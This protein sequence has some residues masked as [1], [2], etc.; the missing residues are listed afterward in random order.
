METHPYSVSDYWDGPMDIDR[1][2]AWCERLRERLTADEVSFGMVFL[3]P[4]YGK[5]QEEIL[6]VI[7]IHCRVP[8]LLG[9][10]GNSLVS[11]PFEYEGD[12]GISVVLYYLPGA[13]LKPFY[14]DPGQLDAADIEENPGFVPQMETSLNGWLVF[15][16]PFSINSEKLL[17]LINHQYPGTAVHGG[18][19]SGYAETLKT[20]IFLDGETYSSGLVGLAVGGDVTFASL[21][22]QG[23]QPIGQSFTVT[24]ANNNILDGIANRQA[25]EVLNEVFSGLSDDQKMK[26]R[27]KLHVGFVIDEY[28][29]SFVRGD[30]LVRNLI[31][32]DPM[33]GALLVGALPRVGQTMQFQLR[34]RHAAMED[35]N[36]ML[37]YLHEDINGRE[38][39][40]AVLTTCTGRGEQF[41]KVADF[42]AG[43]IHESL[44][45]MGM[46]GFF[47]NGEFGPVCGMNFVHGYSATLGVF[48]PKG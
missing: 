35:L 18:L 15:A 5:H 22:S 13:E 25:Y 12:S 14:V 8:I 36:R 27:G 19:A 9:C 47:C 23:C 33:R 28:K 4:N 48:V 7:R 2:E 34:D 37:D 45:P 1:F 6:E 16:D 42:D 11:G 20:Q 32:A 46:A 10:T 26:S 3:T 24:S 17:D 41:F 44:G 21:V 30:F 29:E 40:G 31:G 38:V 39:Y 43:S